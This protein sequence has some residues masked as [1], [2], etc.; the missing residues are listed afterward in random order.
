MA[1]FISTTGNILDSR[2][3]ALVN[4]VNCAGVMSA[5]LARQFKARYPEM[6]Q[7][8]RADCRSG[9]VRIGEVN[10]YPVP[11]GKTVVNLPTKIEWQNPSNI[12]YVAWGLTTLRE[13]VQA[14]GIE[15]VAV[16]PL[17]CGL[18]GLEWTKVQP[19]IVRLLDL[20]DLRV[21]IYEPARKRKN[22]SFSR[23]TTP[24]FRPAT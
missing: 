11:G 6:F 10:L 24:A 15:T 5:G 17:G 22:N 8:Y 14:Q 23:S 12:D 7:H 1:T 16:P 4:P 2:S 13:A 9:K 18:G 3:Q 20:P 21:E 19:I